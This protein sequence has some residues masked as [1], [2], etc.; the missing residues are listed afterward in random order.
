MCL[1]GCAGGVN[2]CQRA[3]GR[4][5]KRQRA[6]KLDASIGK[7]ELFG[8]A[9]CYVAL[10][11]AMCARASVCESRY[12]FFVSMPA[13]LRAR[14]CVRVCVC[15]CVRARVCLRARARVCGRAGAC[16]CK[17]ARGSVSSEAA[18]VDAAD[19]SVLPADKGDGSC[20]GRPKAAC[21]QTKQQDALCC[22]SAASSRGMLHQRRPFA[23]CVATRLYAHART[24]RPASKV[25]STYVRGPRQ[26]I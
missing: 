1:H 3:C 25:G 15:L 14:A 12:V 23:R 7:E 11:T 10:L 17:R 21:I 22:T 19:S 16:V 18:E 2:A 9:R 24:H 4:R 5:R 26:T 8:G 6:L 20:N 13:S